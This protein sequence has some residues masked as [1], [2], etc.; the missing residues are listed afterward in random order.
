M[1]PLVASHENSPLAARGL[2]T[3]KCRGHVPILMQTL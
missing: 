1:K 3:M 2:E